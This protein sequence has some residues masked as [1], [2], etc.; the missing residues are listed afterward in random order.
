MNEFKERILIVDDE[1]SIRAGV[2]HKLELEGYDCET[3]ANGAQALDMI[4]KKAF[5]LVL[6]DIKMPGLSGIEVLRQV[7]ARYPDIAIIMLSALVDTEIAVEAMRMGAYDYITK[8]VGLNTLVMRVQK[9]LERS[10]LVSE[11]R[12]YQLQLEQKVGQ[13]VGQ[14]RQYYREAIEAL[15][16]EEIALKK[17]EATRRAKQLGPPPDA[18]NN[19]DLEEVYWQ[20][21]RSLAQL[22]EAHE[23]YIFGHSERVSILAR[24]IAV[25]AGCSEDQVKDI[26]LAAILHDVGKISIPDH[27]LFKPGRLT[28][29]ERLELEK[30]PATAVN[31]IRHTEYFSNI[32]PFICRNSMIMSSV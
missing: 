28:P 24:K 10:H 3:A 13:Q 29:T 7:A 9:A 8:P 31:I 6:L 20:M 19:T 16:R 32:L 15:A 27:I 14:I 4:F 11:N 5:D 12:E 18:Q 21:A 25:R 30:H 22:S 23:P 2:S 17:L 26:Q 1:E